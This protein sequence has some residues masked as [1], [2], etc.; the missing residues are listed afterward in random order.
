VL[1][2]LS[3][4]DDYSLARFLER[5]KSDIGDREALAANM[6]ILEG[7]EA[8]VERLRPLC[9]AAPF[10][11]EKRLVIIEGLLRRFQPAGRSGRQAASKKSAVQTNEH[12]TLAR[13]L[14]TVPDSTVL[15][16]V[17]YEI[18]VGNPLYK[19]L[20]ATA[21]VQSFPLL[22]ETGVKSWLQKRVREEGG[23]I[24]NEAVNMLARL[25]GSN[26]WI[27]S[28]EI[29]KLL[30]YASGRRIEEEDVRRLVGYTQQS[31]VFSM[32]DAIV[33]FRTQIAERLLQQQLQSGASPTYLL[34]MLARQFRLIIRARD[35]ATPKMSASELCNRLG[36]N[37]DF[38]ARKTLEQANRYSLPRLKQVY[39][40]LLETDMA[41][42]TGRYEPELALD[43]L[44]T[45]LCQQRQT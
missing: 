14:T 10:L 34:A 41:I 37:S 40:Q 17:E 36:L 25:V 31:S 8:T 2:I 23:S 13:Y 15:V 1:Y 32:V 16:L 4:R 20:A 12:E 19:A 44:V 35:I 6:T 5:I 29:D 18:K 7:Q 39:R 33:E 43:I 28:G 26:L 24:S 22:K 30:L 42:K 9:E 45:E 38:V 21:N 11:A 27:M 3:G